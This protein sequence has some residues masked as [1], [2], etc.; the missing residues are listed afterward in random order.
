[1]FQFWD[2]N[3]V[4]VISLRPTHCSK[5]AISHLKQWLFRIEAYCCC[6]TVFCGEVI[7]GHAVS[8]FL[9]A[10]L[11]SKSG[12]HAVR[13]AGKYITYLEPFAAYVSRCNSGNKR[14]NT[15]AKHYFV[16]LNSDFKHLLKNWYLRKFVM[17]AKTIIQLCY[18]SKPNSQQH[19]YCVIQEQQRSL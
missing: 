8:S 10:C 5:K 13:V 19:E 4:V 7:E 15:T 9:E 11:Y 16:N 3:C 2:L 1:M 18:G 17:Q 14:G 12:V 6:V